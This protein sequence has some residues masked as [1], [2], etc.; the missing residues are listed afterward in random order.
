MLKIDK[1]K[2]FTGILLSIAILTSGCAAIN[3]SL[4]KRN[5]DVQT[6]ASET[7]FLEPVKPSKRIIF[8]SLRNTSDKDLEIKSEIL[9]KLRTNGYKITDD[10]DEAQFMLQAN[11]LKV[12]KSN[13]EEKDSYLEAGFSGASLGNA[14]SSQSDS[15]KG[16][17]LGALVGVVAD[18]FVDDTFYTMV[19]DLQLRE[20]PR[21]NEIVTQSQTENSSQGSST[22]ISQSSDVSTV[23]WKTYHTRI[24][25]TANQVNLE[26]EDALPFL[27]DGLIRSIA[28]FFAE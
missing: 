27:Q 2:I 5:L 12:G 8:V 3:T 19:T 16:I 26:F 18:S 4:E 17:V 9:E 15:G 24:V 1:N 14:V 20:R 21:K 25:S 23:E 7:V 6:K 28:G 11:I 13:L 22:D 10:P